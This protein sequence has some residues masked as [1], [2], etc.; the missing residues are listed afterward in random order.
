MKF[1]KIPKEYF[2][3]I[4][5]RLTRF[6]PAYIRYKR[7][8]DDII[9]KFALDFKLKSLTLDEEIKIVENIFNSSL[10]G[11]SDFK[12]NDVILNL[13]NKYFIKNELSNKYINAR[14]D[15]G[16]MV[17]CIDIENNSA[18]NVV[19]LKN[20]VQSD[21]D[22]DK[23]RYEKSLLYP[24]EKIVLCEG[25]TERVLLNSLFK[26]YDYDFE[27]EGILLISAGG[28][29]QVAR[30]YYE[31]IEYTKIPFLILLD[32]DAFLI[33]MLIDE[34]LRKM[35]KI[36]IL[37]SGEFEDLFSFEIL[38]NAVNI[39]HNS[40]LQ[41]VRE[42]FLINNSNVKNLENIYRKYG[43]GEFKKA[44]FANVLKDYVE[45]NTSKN[46]FLNSEIKDVVEFLKN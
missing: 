1:K 13:E 14:I 39:A 45:Q 35:D 25:E 6:E 17:G 8:F 16:G 21:F 46:D 28:K 27:R 18:K 29:N 15:I 4:L 3:T 32:K 30:K 40:E 2:S 42:D 24:I 19:W 20:I 11:S 31:M 38:K 34:K 23:I 43:F 33:K 36:Y 26:K 9:N 10:D 12:I 5:D 7:V 37:K 44:H 41:C 22:L